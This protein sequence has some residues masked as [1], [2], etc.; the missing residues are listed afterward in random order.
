V[1]PAEDEARP[2]NMTAIEAVNLGLAAMPQAMLR[3]TLVQS[4]AWG[5][6]V[7]C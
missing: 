6:G 3:S 4:R 2:L 7:S 5:S 1:S